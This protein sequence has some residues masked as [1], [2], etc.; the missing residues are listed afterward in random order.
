MIG[1]RV[2]AAL[3]D[4]LLFG[5]LQNGGSVVLDY[6]ADTDTITT[7]FEESAEK[8]ENLENEPSLEN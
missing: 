4:E 3:A 2:R 7:A 1:E 6:D 8:P 5:R